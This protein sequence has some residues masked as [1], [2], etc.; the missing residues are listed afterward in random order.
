M[1]LAKYYAQASKDPSSKI[2]AVLVN[3]HNQVVGLGYN[4]FPRGV[5]DSEKRY[6]NRD[7]KLKLVVH[8]EVNA[9]VSAGKEARGGTLYVWPSFALPPIC[10]ECC[11]VAITAGVVEIVGFESDDNSDR[12]ARWKDSIAISKMMCDEAG[13]TYRGLIEHNDMQEFINELN[14]EDLTQ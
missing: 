13:V 8:A 7:V 14:K 12:A 3:T 6:N 4:G 10:N 1:G 11:K 5:E 9:V 2:G